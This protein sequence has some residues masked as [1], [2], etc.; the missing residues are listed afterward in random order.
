[1]V[2]GWFSSAFGLVALSGQALGGGALIVLCLARWAPERVP[3]AGAGHPP[4]WRDLG[5]LLLMWVVTWAYLAFMEFLIIWAENLP[6]EIAWYVPRLQT[7]WR[8]VAIAL[9][10]L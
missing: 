7:G 2:T 5:D 4:V 8:A 1:M 10:V 3:A 6:H 9:V